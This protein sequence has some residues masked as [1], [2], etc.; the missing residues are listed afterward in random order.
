M[1]TGWTH[2][3]GLSHVPTIRPS[4][5]MIDGGGGGGGLKSVLLL[6]LEDHSAALLEFLL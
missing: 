6:R 3:R 5:Q 4:L 2:R 1:G